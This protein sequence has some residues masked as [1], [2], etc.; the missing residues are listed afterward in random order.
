MKRCLDPTMHSNVFLLFRTAQP[1]KDVTA[2]LA[3]SAGC[4]LK[5]AG[6]PGGALGL[7]WSALI[8]GI[9]KVV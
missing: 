6:H 8:R 4:C 7:S 1:L 3:V 5:S 9:V 2:K